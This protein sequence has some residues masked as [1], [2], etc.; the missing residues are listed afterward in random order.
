[1]RKSVYWLLLI[2]MLIFNGAVGSEEKPKES[3]PTL[4]DTIKRCG[5]C[6]GMDG[7]SFIKTMPSI[8]GMTREYFIHSLDAYKNQSRTS[9][10]SKMMAN[11][12]HSLT[13]EDVKQLAEYYAKQKYIP[14]NQE[15]DATKAE[16][17]KML[18]DKY[19]EKCHEDAGRITEN[20]YGILAGQWIPYLVQSLKDYLDKK[21]PVAPMMITKMKKMQ[22]EHGKE[23]FEQLA[24]YY[25]SLK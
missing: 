20:N 5:M 4:E 23:S 16:K 19:C 3:K 22:A 11:Y 12:T 1:M 18:H 10:P 2:V 9:E 14:R 15:F 6:H 21:R 17:G 13:D 8:A 7:N 24:H 25:A